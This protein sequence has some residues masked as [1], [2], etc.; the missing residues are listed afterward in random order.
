L[1]AL[2]E[3]KNNAKFKGRSIKLQ[4][5][6]KQ[7]NSAIVNQN[8]KWT[9][10]GISLQNERC[11]RDKESVRLSMKYSKKKNLKKKKN[12]KKHLKIQKQNCSL[13]Y[14]INQYKTKRWSLV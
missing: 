10:N 11:T 9:D 7:T 3:F 8:W 4:V 13:H 5:N 2:K 12:Q 6:N 1:K 14:S